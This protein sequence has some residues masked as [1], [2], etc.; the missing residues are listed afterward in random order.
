MESSSGLGLRREGEAETDAPPFRRTGTA[1]IP[2]LRPTSPFWTRKFRIMQ[3]TL[4]GKNSR[5]W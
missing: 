5:N 4:A 2:T 1:N 3:L